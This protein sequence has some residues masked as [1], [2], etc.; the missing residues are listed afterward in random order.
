MQPASGFHWA[1]FVPESSRLKDKHIKGEN[2][3]M[4]VTVNTTTCSSYLKNYTRS[5]ASIYLQTPAEDDGEWNLWKNNKKWGNFS[6]EAIATIFSRHFASFSKSLSGNT[7]GFSTWCHEKKNKKHM[8]LPFISRLKLW[9]QGRSTAMG[10][11]QVGT[12]VSG[13]RVIVDQSH[14]LKHKQNK[15]FKH[16]LSLRTMQRSQKWQKMWIYFSPVPAL[17]PL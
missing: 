6:D 7:Q 12:V 13:M 11:G 1:C 10:L 15:S 9:K 14:F 8:N 4:C 2:G 17:F 3:H 16:R 5:K